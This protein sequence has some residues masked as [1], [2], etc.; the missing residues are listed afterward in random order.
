MGKTQLTAVERSGHWAVRITWPNGRHDY[1]GKYTSER[2][3]SD[4]IKEHRWM[5]TRPVEERDLDLPGR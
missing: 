3:A 4:W 2:E 1:F 5:T